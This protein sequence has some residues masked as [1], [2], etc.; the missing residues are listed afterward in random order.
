M[1]P[2][3]IFFISTV[4]TFAL[5]LLEQIWFHVIP[6]DISI[7]LMITIGIIDIAGLIAYL[8]W[9]EYSEE[10]KLKKDKFQN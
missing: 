4:F 10:K 9:G 3:H 2:V 7:K 1:R 6:S 5:L 8:I